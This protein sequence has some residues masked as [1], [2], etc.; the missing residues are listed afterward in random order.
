MR[1]TATRTRPAPRSSARRGGSETI[2]IV[3]V[4]NSNQTQETTVEAPMDASLREVF[5]AALSDFNIEPSDRELGVD[6]SDFEEPDTG[7]KFKDLDQTVEESGLE[8]E[9]VVHYLPKIEQ[10]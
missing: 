9:D 8:N 7:T 3:V 4:N 5:S 10:A 1:N 2:D 6:A